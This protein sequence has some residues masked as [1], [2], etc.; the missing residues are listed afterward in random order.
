MARASGLRPCRRD[1]RTTMMCRQIAMTAGADFNRESR[2]DQDVI[3]PESWPHAAL[4]SWPRL[5]GM[6][7][8]TS[9]SRKIFW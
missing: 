3:S 4:M 8:G 2:A 7:T 1:A 9:L 5:E 6:K